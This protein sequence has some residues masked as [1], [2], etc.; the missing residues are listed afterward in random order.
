MARL[1]N[2]AWSAP[3]YI[4][5]QNFALGLVLGIDIFNVVLLINSAEAMAGF[6]SH[7][8]TLGADTAVVAG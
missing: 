1:P 5:P 6:K 7:K 4:S 2:G 8:F 3:S